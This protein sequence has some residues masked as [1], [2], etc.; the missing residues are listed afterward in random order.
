MILSIVI[1][2]A[3]RASLLVYNNTYVCYARYWE[4][5]IS[6]V[7]TAGTYYLDITILDQHVNIFNLSFILTL[8]F[9]ASDSTKFYAS[10][11]NASI[12][13]PIFTK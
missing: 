6:I 13:S 4:I 3:T 8:R 9:Y 10:Y 2:L 7:C 12:K 5:L 11:F 1:C